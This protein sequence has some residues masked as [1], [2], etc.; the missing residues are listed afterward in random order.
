MGSLIG[1]ARVSTAEQSVDLQT[2]ELRAAGRVKVF[3]E[4]ICGAVDRR[5][6]LDRALEQ[7][8][9]GDTLVV[10]RLDRLGRSLRHLIDTVT[11]L[12][13]QGVGFRSLR[14]SI[15]TTTSGGRLVFHLFGALAQFERE[16]I[17]DRTVAGLASGRVGGRP[18]K[19]T[20]DLVRTARR[21]YEE[22][23]LTVAEIGGVLGVSRTSIYG[24]VAP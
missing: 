17:R 4:Q 5:P 2:D 7:L 18:P 16:V 22:R 11:G 21:L 20:A 15:D 19:L 8:R 1:Y 13:A 23:A 9:A 14:E 10:W 12:D 24:G 3:T 6:Q